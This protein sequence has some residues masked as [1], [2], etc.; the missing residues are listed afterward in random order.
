MKNVRVRIKSTV[1]LDGSPH[2]KLEGRFC[3]DSG[4]ER[5]VSL[6]KEE[7]SVRVTFRFE[8]LHT[9]DIMEHDFSIGEQ[10]I[11][12][13]WKPVEAGIFPALKYYLNLFYE[14]MSYSFAEDPIAE[15]FLVDTIGFVNYHTY[16]RI[17]RSGWISEH[18]EEQTEAEIIEEGGE[19]YSI[20]GSDIYNDSGEKLGE[21]NFHYSYDR[22]KADSHLDNLDKEDSAPDNTEQNTLF[23]M[24]SSDIASEKL[25]YDGDHY[26]NGDVGNF[27]YYVLVLV[28]LP[29]FFRKYNS[30]EWQR[31]EAV[32]RLRF[33][34]VSEDEIKDF[35][36]NGWI[37][38]VETDGNGNVSRG[39]N[40][41]GDT[42]FSNLGW[43][44]YY[45]NVLKALRGGLP[46]LL[47]KSSGAI[48]MEAY[49]YI[50]PLIEERDIYRSEMK[51][52]SQKQIMSAIVF[53]G[54]SDY[55]YGSIVVELTKDGPIR[56][57]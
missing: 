57:G 50:E 7:G 42:F 11:A 54:W 25:Y 53:S 39:K 40:G 1:K 18:M 37:P 52:G 30:E 26:V 41:A 16:K 31:K 5:Q 32:R 44:F 43:R 24:K 22:D 17:K 56:T 29:E 3:F 15:R 8:N 28:T 9:K 14:D 49:L 47:F 21:L 33:L 6:L 35:E 20:K 46:Y 36:E 38:M 12:L 34:G 45:H 55:E 2:F 51:E 19:T 10:A 4:N 13:P 23:S 48:P 27:E